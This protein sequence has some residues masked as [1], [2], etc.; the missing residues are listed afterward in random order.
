MLRLTPARAAL[1]LTLTAASLASA[2]NAPAKVRPQGG[3]MSAEASKAAAHKM[4]NAELIRSADPD[5]VQ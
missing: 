1:L 4:S 3:A 2:Q 5:I